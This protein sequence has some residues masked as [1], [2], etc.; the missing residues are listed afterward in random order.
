MSGD[1]GD[2]FTAA[3]HG[4]TMMSASNLS[5]NATVSPVPQRGT[6]A[7]FFGRSRKRSI[8][9]SVSSEGSYKGQS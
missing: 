7:T 9:V 8:S 5:N 1:S 6:L 4:T 2:S 3:S